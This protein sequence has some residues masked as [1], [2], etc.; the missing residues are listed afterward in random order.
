MASPWNPLL[1]AN[2]S[3]VVIKDRQYVK[4]QVLQVFIK[5]SCPVQ[6]HACTLVKAPSMLFKSSLVKTMIPFIHPSSHSRSLRSGCD[7]HKNGIVDLTPP[8][9]TNLQGPYYSS[10]VGVVVNIRKAWPWFPDPT[11]SRPCLLENPQCLNK[12]FFVGLDL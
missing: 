12:V 11:V 2:R 5:I 7:P 3:V 10:V 9:P 4:I 1:H 8:W 6:H